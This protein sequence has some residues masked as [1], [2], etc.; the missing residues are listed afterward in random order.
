MPLKTPKTLILAA[1][2]LAISAAAAIPTFAASTDTP[3]DA[4]T[5]APAVQ[6]AAADPATPPGPPAQR[7]MQMRGQILF[8]LVD[9]NADGA[10]DLDEFATFEKA[11]FDSIDANKDGKLTPD[12]F[13]SMAGGMRGQAW[14]GG[15]DDDRGRGHHRGPGFFGQ[16]DRQGFGPGMRQGM[17]NDDDRPGFG[18][19]PGMGPRQ[20][21]MDDDDRPGMG[22][23]AG[24]GQQLGY[25][26]GPGPLGPR[27]FASLDT[28]GDG[29]ISQDE[30]NARVPLGPQGPRNQ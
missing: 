8:N 9:K 6:M 3:V 16:G 20:G 13:T 21:M 17:R 12:E 2:A 27:D 26:N 22:P 10:I 5:T 28:N 19:G 14:R 15:D 24:R 11:T 25:N 7:P 29:V 23:G 30:F 18:R 1:S 4:S